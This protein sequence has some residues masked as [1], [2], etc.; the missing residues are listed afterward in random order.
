VGHGFV[1]CVEGDREAGLGGQ[2]SPG[3]GHTDARLGAAV[4]VVEDLAAVEVDDRG[5]FVEAGDRDQVDGFAHRCIPSLRGWRW[6]AVTMARWAAAWPA[7]CSLRSVEA[8]RVWPPERGARPAA[9]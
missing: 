5:G 6:V 3:P 2:R 9:S 8:V 4:G 7:V 1:E